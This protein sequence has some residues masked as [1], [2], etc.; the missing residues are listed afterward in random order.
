MSGVLSS[1]TNDPLLDILLLSVDESLR[2]QV[3]RSDKTSSYLNHL[4]KLSP[5]VL[6]DEKDQLI[7]NNKAIE[8]SISKLAENSYLQ[9][10]V[11][12]QSMKKL[13]V[14]EEKFE[15]EV[16]RTI[17]LGTQLDQEAAKLIEEME[18]I[19]YESSR[20][21][22]TP[23]V[24]LDNIDKIQ[25]ILELPSLTLTCVHNGYYSEAL[26]LAS[27]TRRLGVRFNGIGIIGNIVE[28]VEQAMDEMIVQLLELLKHNV[29]LPMVIKT[30][31]YLRRLKPFS[32]MSTQ[33]CTE[34]LQK[35]FLTLRMV[36]INNQLNLLNSI[37]STIDPDKYLKRY[38]EVI[39]EHVFATIVNFNTVFLNK[40]EFASRSQASSMPISP[41][42]SSAS[43]ISTVPKSSSIENDFIEETS[44]CFN[45]Q[46]S[47]LGPFMRKIISD[48]Y[49]KLNEFAPK[50][51]DRHL[52]E[53]LWLQIAYCSASM[54]RVGFEFG[55][56]LQGLSCL[57]NNDDPLITSEEWNRA[58][59]K[60]REI[61]IRLGS[62]GNR[63]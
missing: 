8:S 30:I 47:I 3:L 61:S 39:R 21:R 55:S 40:S 24:L 33:K 4:R 54:S 10:I 59:E 48:L 60:Q 49:D 62:S 18:A 31:S 34:Q 51:T 41:S 45:L 36:F 38:I 23:V 14:V 22:I 37:A 50:I 43:L 57:S 16:G 56:I 26:D 29:R 27:H 42:L 25:D 11:A 6:E 58:L 52:R 19:N 13:S 63:A 20:Q 12:S 17:E 1:A 28:E 7:V 2:N 44:Q 46:G 32:T 9:F 35:L 15:H 53:S 5:D